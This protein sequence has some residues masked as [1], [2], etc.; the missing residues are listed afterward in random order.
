MTT[1]IFRLEPIPSTSMSLVI[2]VVSA[3]FFVSSE[4]AAAST[5]GSNQP[6]VI[7]EVERDG[8]YGYS[9]S[10][11]SGFSFSSSKVLREDAMQEELAEF[12]S[13]KDVVWLRYSAAASDPEGGQVRYVWSQVSPEEPVAII[14]QEGSLFPSGEAVRM[15]LCV[16]P[17][18]AEITLQVVAID[19]SGAMSEPESVVVKAASCASKARWARLSRF[20]ELRESAGQGDPVSQ[21]ALAFAY[22]KGDGVFRDEKHGVELLR[23]Y[24]EQGNVRAQ[25]SWA[26]VLLKGEYRIRKDREEALKWFR[27]G[28]EQG[29]DH[30]QYVMGWY[31]KDKQKAFDWYK[32]SAEQSNKW[33]QF[34]L[35]KMLVE[36][37]GVPRDVAAAKEWMEKSAS[38]G[39]DRARTWVEN[40]DVASG[41]DESGNRPPQL[42]SVAY[43][44]DERPISFSVDSLTV[45]NG[46][47][48]KGQSRT[49]T[50]VWRKFKVRAEDF[51]A[52][53]IRY[54]V[55]QV[56]PDA[57]KAVIG[58]ERGAFKYHASGSEVTFAVCF[59][60]ING[61]EFAFQVTAEDKRGAKSD[62]KTIVLDAIRSDRCG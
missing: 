41:F 43:T 36:G 46:E 52:E 10:S 62:P 21:N 6:P 2:M 8:A 54:V 9:Q 61:G 22:L 55:V 17:T 33:G 1:W 12:R 32:L 27:A 50:I 18:G 49:N 53:S 42:T 48:T 40:W 44:E 7:S 15:K 23:N 38:Q 26:F 3:M 28:A 47:V 30:A 37:D 45:R 35:A 60:Q 57:P 24:A 11:G 4:Y 19:E 31:E 34:S 16:P 14:E 56:S 58:G 13:D 59:P 5:E 51:D 20:A 39:H 29:H 25:V